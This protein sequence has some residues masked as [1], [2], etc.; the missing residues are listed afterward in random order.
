M[1][2][3]KKAMVYTSPDP[4]LYD[5][6][7]EIQFSLKNYSGARK[8]WRTSLSLTRKKKKDFSGE[9]PNPQELQEKIRKVD[10]FL[11]NSY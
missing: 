8:S 11:Q 1:S 2:Q 7:G 5:H 4:V 9:V 10:Q 6:L 3:I